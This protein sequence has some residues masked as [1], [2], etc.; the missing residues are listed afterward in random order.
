VNDFRQIPGY[1]GYSVSELAL[2]RSDRTGSI[3]AFDAHGKV[4][5][6]VGRRT[7]RVYVGPLMALAGLMGGMSGEDAADLAR[8]RE[9]AVDAIARLTL[10]EAKLRDTQDTLDK[11]RKANAMLLGLRDAA[12]KQL[13][14]AQQGMVPPPVAKPKRGRPPHAAE[15]DAEE[16]TALGEDW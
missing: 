1:D 2:V 8:A 16:D 3:L 5:L 4:G 9:E 12:L 14:A 6:R 15:E 11:A 13:A 10:A 7:V